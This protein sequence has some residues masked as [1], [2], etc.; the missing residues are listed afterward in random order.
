MTTSNNQ[1]LLDALLSI[2]ESLRSIDQTLTHELG[3]ENGNLRL[4]S[5]MLK[6]I[7]SNT[8]GTEKELERFNAGKGF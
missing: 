3:S 5:K 1:D 7:D 2:S 8:Y 6:G 4:I